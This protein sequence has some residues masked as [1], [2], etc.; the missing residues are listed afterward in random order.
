MNLSFVIAK[1]RVIIY[2]LKCCIFALQFVSGTQDMK[3][4]R[5]ETGGWV[6]VID[7]FAFLRERKGCSWLRRH[8]LSVRHR[9]WL[10]KASRI[11]ASDSR[12]AEDAVKYY[13]VPKSKIEIRP[14]G[15]GAGRLC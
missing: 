3:K 4:Y 7:D 14:S 1:R 8:Y 6:V 13:F 2:I 15:P 5:D 12:V 9:K 10:R 11:V